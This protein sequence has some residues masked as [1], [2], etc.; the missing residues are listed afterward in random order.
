ML[1]NVLLIL[2]GAGLVTVGFLAATLAERIRNPGSQITTPAQPH[3]ITSA[4]HPAPPRHVQGPGII[5]IDKSVEL[6][7]PATPTPSRAP[8]E[9]VPLTR[10]P[11]GPRPE[12]KTHTNDVGAED[13][14]AALVAAGYKKPIA[15]EAT[16]ACQGHER[17][18][19]E[20]WTVAAL[21]RCGKGAAS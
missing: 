13:V 14:I 10:V 3:I 9:A 2:L 6:L 12:S 7:R 15:T 19:I 1:S 17:A 18:T 20:G 4:A 5:T 8:M 11:R 16:W 21:R